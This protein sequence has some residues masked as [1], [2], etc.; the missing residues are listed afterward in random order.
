M[1]DGS[2]QALLQKNRKIAARSQG[3]T[4]LQLAASFFFMFFVW[5]VD[6]AVVAQR[7]SES[8]YQVRERDAA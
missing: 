2:F 6:R 1:G 8:R 3:A 4:I 7:S 5:T